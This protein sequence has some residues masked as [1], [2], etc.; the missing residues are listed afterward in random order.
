MK[1]FSCLLLSLVLLVSAAAMC[2]CSKDGDDDQ[3]RIV[4]DGKEFTAA[5]ASYQAWE[6][7]MASAKY[8]YVELTYFDEEGMQ[9]IVVA[10]RDSAFGT[11]YTLAQDGSQWKVGLGAAY[12]GDSGNM[13]LIR[14]GKVYVQSLSKRYT[15]GNMDYRRYKMALELILTDGK[16]VSAT[17][18]GPFSRFLISSMEDGDE[19]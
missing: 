11:W 2:S 19:E 8:T 3:N 1:I 12:V 14:S 18:T 15:S 6:E 4:V 7:I 17:Y 13:N 10:L 9:N 5:Y 16:T